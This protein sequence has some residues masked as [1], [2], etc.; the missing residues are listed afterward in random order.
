MRHS[1]ERILIT[2]TGLCRGRKGSPSK[3]GAV[4]F[5]GAAEASER[6]W[7]AGAVIA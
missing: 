2:H 3:L 4:S 6:L 5:E 1:S 7:P